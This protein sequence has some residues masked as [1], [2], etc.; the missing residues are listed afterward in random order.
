MPYKKQ[1]KALFA[2]FIALYR[3]V[4]LAVLARIL[5]PATISASLMLKT[6]LKYKINGVQWDDHNTTYKT[7]LGFKRKSK[8][9]LLYEHLS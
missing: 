8:Q 2:L 6:L 3:K 1:S 5:S 4:P 9:K 7:F